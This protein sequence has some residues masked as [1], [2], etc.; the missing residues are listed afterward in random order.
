MGSAASSIK[1]VID[2]TSGNPQNHRLQ[3]VQKD[4]SFSTRFPYRNE[5]LRARE[6]MIP[7]LTVFIVR[8]GVEFV[9]IGNI[10]SF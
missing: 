5:Q 2:C 10:F 6:K 3:P 4:R 1:L 7:R 8:I 9:F